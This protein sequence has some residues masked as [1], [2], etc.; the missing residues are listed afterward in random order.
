MTGLSVRPHASTNCH[1]L[2]ATDGP[3]RRIAC[4]VSITSCCRHRRVNELIHDRCSRRPR[5][6]R[7]VGRTALP[8]EMVLSNHAGNH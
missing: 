1:W 7:A 2:L 5:P 6:P 4:S 3:N 8:S